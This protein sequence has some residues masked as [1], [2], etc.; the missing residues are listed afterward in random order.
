MSKCPDSRRFRIIALK[1][2]PE[3]GSDGLKT[4]PH[5]EQLPNYESAVVVSHQLARQ[6]PHYMQQFDVDQY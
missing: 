6:G 1:S 3:G 4:H 5:S 2:S